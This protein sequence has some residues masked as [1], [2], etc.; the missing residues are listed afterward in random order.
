MHFILYFCMDSVSDFT[1]CI[2]PSPNKK[3]FVS[4][5]TRGPR[6]DALIYFKFLRKGSA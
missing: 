2:L 1:K 4:V 3:C 5:H 6:E